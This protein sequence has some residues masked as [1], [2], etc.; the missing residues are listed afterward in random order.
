MKRSI[1]FASLTILTAAFADTLTL[2]NGELVTGTWLG[3]EHG[4]ISFLVGNKTVK[5]ARDKVTKITFGDEGGGA[6][7]AP[8]ANPPADQPERQTVQV[9][10]SGPPLTPSAPSSSGATDLR[11]LDVVHFW[12]ADGPISPLE[13]A[14][15]IHVPADAGAPAT[16][17]VKGA[18]SP[19]RIK[20]APATLFL[21]R[22]AVPA[23][24]GKI[25]L[26]RLSSGGNRKP[27]STPGIA[28]SWRTVP[29]SIT[30]AA[31]SMGL[32]PVGELGDG[33]YAFYRAGASTA[34]C[35][36]VDS[37]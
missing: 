37:H 12:D 19:F 4:Q 22:L 10:P 1:L 24:A 21:V 25:R 7:P 8:P 14:A 20:R 35:F 27:A 15:V 3:V 11:P 26:Y 17:E 30:K 2:R 36:G 33:E 31:D 28:N 6:R 16:W 9:L 18:R 13:Q 29:I 5:Y 34:Y 32:A 23:D